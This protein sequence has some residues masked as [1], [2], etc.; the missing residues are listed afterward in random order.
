MKTFLLGVVVG[1][2]VVHFTCKLKRRFLF[3][4]YRSIKKVFGSVLWIRQSDLPSKD[5]PP[6]AICCKYGIMG[7]IGNTPLVYLPAL[8]EATG[9][10]IFAKLEFRNPGG[11]SK[12]RFA[13]ALLRHISKKPL[14]K[15]IHEATT[16]STGVSLALFSRRFGLDCHIYAPWH[17]SEEKARLIELF[18]AEL[19]RSRGTSIVDRDMFVNAA[20]TAGTETATDFL[21]DQFESE[22]NFL[23]HYQTTGPE[24]W[25]QTWGCIDAFVMGVG[26]GGTIAG[27]G[28]YI[29][30]QNPNCQ[31]IVAD[32]QGSSL[33]NYIAHGVLWSAEH[34]EG[35]RTRSQVDS[36]VEGVGINRMTALLKQCKADASFSVADAEAREMALFLLERESLFVGGSSAVHCAAIK[37]WASLQSKRSAPPV[38]VTVFSDEGYRSIQKFWNF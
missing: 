7:T 14:I 8:S 6:A 35:Q 28:A 26:T 38:V 21:A 3:L 10:S 32:P 23:T 1:S 17:I 31:V 18:G 16:G 30:E 34:A 2:L 11:S 4:L 22:I 25:Q 29:K 9:C 15:R 12:D 5:P 36:D 24:I 13:F 33:H 37:K 27:V 20:K 19:H